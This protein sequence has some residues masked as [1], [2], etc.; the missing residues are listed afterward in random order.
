MHRTSASLPDG[1]EI[2]KEGTHVD[3]NGVARVFTAGDID[4]TAA[5]YDPK[6]H[7]APLTIGHPK[8]DDPR[9]GA[10]AKLHAVTGA[11]GKRTLTMDAV[12]VEPAFAEAVLTKRYPK[13]STAFYP[14]THPQNP[15]PGVWYVRHVGSL[16]G[17]PPAVR[18][19]ADLPRVTQFADGGADLV[20]FS[21]TPHPTKE[22][23]AMSTELQAK[24]DEATRARVAAEAAAAEATTKLTATLATQRTQR[25]AEHVAFA[26]GQMSQGRLAKPEVAECVALLDLVAD[27]ETVQFGEGDDKKPLAPVGLVKRLVERLQPLVAFAE[28]SGHA[29]LPAGGAKGKSDAEIDTAAKSYAAQHKVSYA[30]ALSAVVSFTS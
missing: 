5:A 7:D 14:P 10:V 26:E 2:F 4:A 25:H 9:Y 8:T 12:D 1:I 28:R 3:D 30:E 22:E 16:G 13:R 6:V 21:E 20:C 17:Q 18:G 19:L 23:D 11:D 29:A 15:K 27:S 24:L